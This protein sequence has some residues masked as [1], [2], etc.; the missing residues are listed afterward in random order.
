[1]ISFVIPSFQRADGSI[2]MILNLLHQTV[3]TKYPTEIIL[4]IDETDS[5]KGLYTNYIIQAQ[6]IAR[7]LTP[8]CEIS[9]LTNQT[10]GLVA[11]KNN[12]VRASKY[13][14]IM[15]LDDDLAA[16]DNYV[17]ALL[18]DMQAK[19]TVGAIS[20]FIVSYVSA[21]SHTQPSDYVEEAPKESHL[22]TLKLDSDSGAWRTFFGKKEQVMDWSR[23]NQKISVTTRYTMDYF[24][25]SY[26]FRKSAY[27]KIGGYL[28][29]L[30]SKTSAH[31][32]VDFTFRMRKAGYQ[33]LFNPFVQMWHITVGHGGIYKGADY[34][35]SKEILEKEYKDSIPIFVQSISK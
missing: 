13:E 23:I 33:L 18:D 34:K 9:L 25:N 11:A 17:E 29:D 22:Q 7:E 6:K 15:M 27:N 12:A 31:E 21:I 28:N 30:N 14:Y 10:K 1:M 20:G 32:E 2:F 35:E 24:V 4:S 3:F 26:L 5:Q 16:V 19:P 8:L